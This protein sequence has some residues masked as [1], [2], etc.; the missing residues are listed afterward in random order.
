[1]FKLP[2]GLSVIQMLEGGKILES[3][4]ITS[5]MGFGEHHRSS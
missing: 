4:K 1:M 3:C 5:A 2:G